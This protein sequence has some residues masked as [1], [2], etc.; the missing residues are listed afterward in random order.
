M[1]SAGGAQN[2]PPAVA[3]PGNQRFDV[4][5]DAADPT[6]FVLY[7]AYASEQ[8]ARAHKETPHYASWRETVANMMARPREGVPFKGLFPSGD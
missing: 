8:D 3:E 2:Q 7:E 4:L 5:Q 1:Q 6:H